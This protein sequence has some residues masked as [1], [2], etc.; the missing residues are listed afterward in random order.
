MGHIYVDADEYLDDPKKA[1][2]I[3]NAFMDNLGCGY[4]SQRKT[5]IEM[6]DI[7]NEKVFNPDGVKISVNQISKILH[8]LIVEQKAPIGSST[9]GYFIIDDDIDQQFA[10][11]FLL[12]KRGTNRNKS[13]TLRAKYDTIR[14]MSFPSG[15]NA[16]RQIFK[17]EEKLA[18]DRKKFIAKK[19]AKDEVVIRFAQSDYKNNTYF[20]DLFSSIADVN[21][22]AE[23]LLTLFKEKEEVRFK[24]NNKFDAVGVYLNITPELINFIMYHMPDA[25]NEPIKCQQ[26]VDLL[27]DSIFFRGLIFITVEAVR[28]LIWLLIVNHQQPIGSCI[29]GYFKITN[30]IERKIA[31]EFLQKQGTGGT[32]RIKALETMYIPKIPIYQKLEIAK[33]KRLNNE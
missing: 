17:K 2:R 22:K 30:E 5:R 9:N 8:R 19:D 1:N 3:Y 4:K 6:T 23:S 13:E 18:V 33:R 32:D 28:S 25:N 24:F 7:L 11:D 26:L 12:P 10:L 29:K 31:I 14:K 15:T 21:K 16:K 20:K 27:N